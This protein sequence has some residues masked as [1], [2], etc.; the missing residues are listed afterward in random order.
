MTEPGAVRAAPLM[1]RPLPV[2][3]GIAALACGTVAGGAPQSHSKGFTPLFDGKTLNGWKGDMTL[4]SVKD[5]AITGGFDAPRKDMTFLIHDGSYSNFELHFKYRFASKDG[6]SGVQYRSKPRPDVNPY[7]VE[8]YQANV[9]P[10]D[11]LVRYGMLY[12]NLGRNEIGLLSEDVEIGRDSAGKLTR[13]IKGSVNPV[14]A[15]LA[16]YRPY[17][18]WNDYVVIAYGNRVIHAING[19]L[20]LVATDNDPARLESGQFALQLDPFLALRVEF[21]DIEVKRL[22]TEPSIAGRFVTKAGLPETTPEIPKRPAR[23]PQ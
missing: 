14:E 10:P 4:W 16:D 23:P 6:N 20:A 15:L 18:R 1:R 17:P 12:E 22:T 3:L 7:M 8:G 11:Q 19:K 21:K 9:V 13:K 2:L 5:G